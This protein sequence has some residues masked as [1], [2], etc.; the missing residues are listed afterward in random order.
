MQECSLPNASGSD[1]DTQL[2]IDL[3]KVRTDTCGPDGEEILSILQ[4]LTAC[5]TLIH[6]HASDTDTQPTPSSLNADTIESFPIESPVSYDDVQNEIL[7]PKNIENVSTDANV[8]DG[9]LDCDCHVLVLRDDDL[10]PLALLT[11]SSS[12]TGG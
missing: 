8:S 9:V 10:S 4:P 3:L 5:S 11:R 2:I 12:P 6:S 1:I 7:T